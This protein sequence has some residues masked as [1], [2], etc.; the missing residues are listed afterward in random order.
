MMR[1]EYDPAIQKLMNYCSVCGAPA[2]NMT[3][4]LNREDKGDGTIAYAAAG[5]CFFRC[6]AHRQEAIAF[7]V[8]KIDAQHERGV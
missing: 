1:S 8:A 7:R 3:R 4:N 5:D 6:D 2:T